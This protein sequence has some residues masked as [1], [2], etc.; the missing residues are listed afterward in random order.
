[1]PCFNLT[2]LVLYEFNCHF[3]LIAAEGKQKESMKL[4]GQMIFVKELD[5]LVYL[6]TPMYAINFI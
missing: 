1:M 4:R 2:R 3:S 5:S 6:A